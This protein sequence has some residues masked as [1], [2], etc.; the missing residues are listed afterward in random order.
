[1]YKGNKLVAKFPS[2]AEA[3]KLVPKAD[4]SHVYKVLRGV[5]KTAG[6]FLWKRTTAYN[7]SKFTPQNEGYP[8]SFKTNKS[9]PVGVFRNRVEAQNIA[10]HITIKGKNAG[11]IA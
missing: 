6:G 11:L 5:R 9:T 8:V 2:V 4:E 7:P 1:M 3:I 10:N